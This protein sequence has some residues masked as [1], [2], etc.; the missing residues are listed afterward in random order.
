MLTRQPGL[1]SNSRA[2]NVP[3]SSYLKPALPDCLTRK[4]LAAPFDP[5]GPSSIGRLATSLLVAALL[6]QSTVM[7]RAANPS[8]FAPVRCE[9]EGPSEESS[10][11]AV[12]SAFLSAEGARTRR[13]QAARFVLRDHHTAG[14]VHSSDSTRI[15]HAPPPADQARR[16]G[17]GGPL[18]C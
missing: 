12:P 18:R 7:S 1:K 11:E 10:K 3:Y 5:R 13:A 15:F 14:T 16:N 2:A 9:G 17:A 4:M 6:I 8:W